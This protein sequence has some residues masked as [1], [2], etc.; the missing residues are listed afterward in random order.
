MILINVSYY[1]VGTGFELPPVAANALNMQPPAPGVLGGPPG[2]AAVPTSATPQAVAAPPIAT[3][4]FMLSNM[5]DP[6]T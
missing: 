2:A 5:F 6:T 3:Q 4:C 1:I